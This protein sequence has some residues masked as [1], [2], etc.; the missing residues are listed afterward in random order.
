MKLH[1]LLNLVLIL[2]ML[3]ACQPVMPAAP[4]ASLADQT[5]AAD[6][7]APQG[8]RPASLSPT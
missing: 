5:A 7:P 4:A 3:T 1:Q 2:L 8:N 6:A